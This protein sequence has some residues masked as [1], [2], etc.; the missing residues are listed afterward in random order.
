MLPRIRDTDQE[1]WLAWMGYAFASTYRSTLF[2]QP[3]SNI[4]SWNILHVSGKTG[5][6]KSALAKVLNG[7][8]GMDMKSTTSAEKT[9]HAQLEMF[10][11]TDGAPIMMDEYN[12]TN[13][14][15]Y[16]TDAFHEHLKKS[17]D[18][19]TVEKGNADKSVTQYKLESSPVVIGEQQLPEDMAALPRRAVEI[20]LSTQ[21]VKAGS[22]T[23]SLF[24]EL[25]SLRD[26][27]YQSGVYHHALRWWRHVVDDVSDPDELV[28]EWHE[29]ME[30]I[31]D[32]LDDRGVE[33]NSALEREMHQQ[34]LQT[35][36]F[37]LQRWRFFAIKEGADPAVLFDDADIL[38]VCQY[39]IER[40]TGGSAHSL[41][42][43]DAMLELF[44]DAAG[45]IDGS[46]GE[47]AS[48]AQKYVEHGS[49]YTIANQH[50]DEPG[51]LRI[52]LKS[53]LPELS[54]YVRDYGIDHN[55]YQRSDYYRWFKTSAGDPDS[56]V[57]DESIRTHLDDSQRRCV[58]IDIEQLTDELAVHRTDIIP[59]WE[60][61]PARS[62]SDDDGG[63]GSGDGDSEP[64]HDA[65]D[66]VEHP[67][68]STLGDVTPSQ[69]VASTTGQIEFN[70]EDH[71]A[72]SASTNGPDIK[73]TL[74]DDDTEAKLIAWDADD[75]EL[76]LDDYGSVAFDEVTVRSVE[77]NDYEGTLQL[78]ATQKTVISPE[79]Q[80][81]IDTTDTTDT[82][83]TSTAT[84]DGGEVDIDE[85]NVP[86]DE[87]KRRGKLKGKIRSHDGDPTVD[88]LS[89]R[90][91]WPADTTEN[92]VQELKNDAKLLGTPQ[93][94]YHIID[95]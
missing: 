80:E 51:E 77:P 26:D 90:L 1:Q 8:L 37:G 19:Q 78:V 3:S 55:I 46:S 41:N 73:A 74:A 21:G 64:D 83:A 50:R 36:V 88:E 40:K 28:T 53:A 48:P 95:D 68:V 52:H 7:A 6:G 71:T 45:I 32:G 87:A 63:S 60:R 38:D 93:N 11:A 34:G 75:I 14:R 43:E 56:K 69:P 44:A 10:C 61:I 54:R 79:G 20:S 35:V 66:D 85:S 86:E 24:Q 13:W 16:V 72:A 18:A 62:S 33:L 70:E 58:S 4:D 65:G 94:G 39:L 2:N 76:P 84:T 22:Q 42:N 17:T 47:F 57:T 12:P 49:H 30:W 29:T 91:G 59:P 81:T 89:Q 25:R 5:A 27:N 15:Q 9:P 23:A 92:V 82:T 67:K 31:R